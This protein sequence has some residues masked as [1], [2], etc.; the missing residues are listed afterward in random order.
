[1]LTLR[2]LLTA[3]VTTAFLATGALVSVAPSAHA[4]PATEY[5]DQAHRATN[6]QR[7]QR[8][9]VRLAKNRCLKR[10]AAKQASLMASRSDIFHQDLGPILRTCD[11]SMVGENVAFGFPTGRAVVNR[12][13][14]NSPGHRAN[15]LQPRYRLMGIAARKNDAGVW[16]VAQV[17][18]RR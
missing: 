11:L 3:L 1:M 4:S 8:D 15:I 16:F 14:M 6:K 12:G 10:F 7:A 18:G 17:F 5:A 13:W 9:L 2:R